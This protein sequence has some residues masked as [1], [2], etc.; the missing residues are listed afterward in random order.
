MRRGENGEKLLVAGK[1]E[2]I[3]PAQGK[4]LKKKKTGTYFPM[5]S[6]IKKHF[7]SM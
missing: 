3:P 2:S 4:R 7:S 5:V 6:G 1:P